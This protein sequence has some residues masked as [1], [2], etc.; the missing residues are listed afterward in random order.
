MLTSDFMSFCLLID[1]S[2]LSSDAVLTAVLTAVLAYMEKMLETD[3]ICFCRS[4]IWDKVIVSLYFV[5]PALVLSLLKFKINCGCD[6]FKS[7]LLLF[8]P[9]M[10]ITLLFLDGRYF[11][12][13]ATH[14]SG[15]YVTIDQNPHK[16][17]CKPTNSTL[18]QE[19]LMKTEWWF[20]VSQVSQ[21]VKSQMEFIQQC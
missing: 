8:P 7:N 13:A 3:F 5:A 20:C 16:K 11:T 18:T 17:W 14:W 2:T 12:C 9:F 19:L 1:K 10:W 15:R 6:K 21:T 4:S